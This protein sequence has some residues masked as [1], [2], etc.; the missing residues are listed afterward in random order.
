MPLGTFNACRFQENY[1]S[2]GTSGS[3]TNWLAVGSGIPLRSV[4]DDG[5]EVVTTAASINGTPVTGN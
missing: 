2:E 4:Y 5:E 1:S 3:I